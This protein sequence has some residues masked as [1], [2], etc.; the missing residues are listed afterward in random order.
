MVDVTLVRV[1]LLSV[2]LSCLAPLAHAAS[3]EEVLAAQP[4]EVQARYAARHPQQ[5]LE[6]FGLKPGMTV[7]EVLPGDG[8]YSRILTAFL[9]TDGE[10]IGADYA[11]DMYPK[12][13]FYDEA[14][15]EA[16]KTWATDWPRQAAE[17]ATDDASISAF[18]L[19]SMPAEFAGRAD[20]VLLI[21]ALHNLARYERDGGYL[22]AALADLAR[23][24]KPG[25]VVG[26]V[27]H[28]APAD[29]DGAWAD[30]SNGYLK[31]DFVMET[32]KAAGFEFVGASE[33]NANPKDKPGA[34][35]NVWRLPPT[36]YGA[37]DEADKARL[38][39]IGETDRMTLLFRKPVP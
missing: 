6:F 20:A 12:F 22:G 17:W 1:G 5:T 36:F 18:A 29:A 27:Q 32:M 30:G 31:Q 13:N 28:R 4:A 15:L 7:V 21:R 39:A 23:V 11:A 38:A 3:L 9:G 35:D 14:F 33:V 37:K 2:L 34:Q 19:G 24:L 8:W 25:G 26:I 16:K 10:L